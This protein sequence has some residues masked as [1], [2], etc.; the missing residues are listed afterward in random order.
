M[1]SPRGCD[2][3]L[4]FGSDEFLYRIMVDYRAVI[5]NVAKR[6]RHL[7]RMY[8]VEDLE[9]EAF[10]GVRLA[11]NSWAHAR[12]IKMQFKT[13]LTWHISRHFQGRFNGD[14]KVV[15]IIGQ[16]NAIRVTIPWSKYK[17]SGRAAARA[18]NC[19]TR[20][21]S[22]LVYYD[23]PNGECDEPQLQPSN[24]WHPIH[25]GEETVVDIFDP[26]GT[27][28]VTV[29]RN[30]FLRVQDLIAGYGYAIREYS[31]YDPPPSQST[32]H[33]LTPEAAL[34]PPS[35]Y[36][37]AHE[38][39]DSQDETSHVVD[40]YSRREVFLTTMTMKRYRLFQQHFQKYGLK[41]RRRNPALTP[42]PLE[43][44]D[45]PETPAP[46]VYIQESVTIA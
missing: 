38:S 11:C 40:V 3:S 2:H 1:N 17:K 16:D 23:A 27:L 39:A 4:L 22:L 5:L 37:P 29:P 36:T 18:R 46:M 34:L 14:D 28:I 32:R 26:T 19:T 43:Y 33:T 12:A 13:Y 45:V 7:D 31:I 20:I 24:D 42:E 15:D 41:T 8:D 10:F 25:T 35:G 9:Q 6:F 30:H 44:D 21:R